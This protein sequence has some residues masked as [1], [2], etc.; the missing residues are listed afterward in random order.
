MELPADLSCGPAA[1]RPEPK[2]AHDQSN[3][4]SADLA[5]PVS[6]ILKMQPN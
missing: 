6:P 1:K 2:N 4:F 5:A 3:A